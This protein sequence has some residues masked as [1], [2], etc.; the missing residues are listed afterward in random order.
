MQFFFL[1]LLTFLY[2]FITFVNVVEAY[3]TTF[4]KYAYATI[5]YEGTAHDAE[6]VL[7]IEV[8]V[9]SLIL[10]NTSILSFIYYY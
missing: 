1:R 9:R 8:M 4:H 5:H 10:S 6:Y 2:A 3:E 7:G